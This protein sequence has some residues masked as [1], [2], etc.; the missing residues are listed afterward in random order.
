MALSIIYFNG[1]CAKA[2][3]SLPGEMEPK[4]TPQIYSSGAIQRNLKH[5]H[6]GLDLV[7]RKVLARI[8]KIKGFH[9]SKTERRD[10]FSVQMRSRA[11]MWVQSTEME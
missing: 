5:D 1:E 2:T 6:E 7:A 3:G 10:R 8:S 11:G 4:K 9:L